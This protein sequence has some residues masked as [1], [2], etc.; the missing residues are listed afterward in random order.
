LV[1]IIGLVERFLEFVD[2]KF[3][4]RVEEEQLDAGKRSSRSEGR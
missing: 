2:K 4:G 3:L 1:Y